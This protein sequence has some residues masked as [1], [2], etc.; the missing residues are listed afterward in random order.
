MKKTENTKCWQERG[1][2]VELVYCAGGS[3]YWYSHF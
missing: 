3:V 2:Q 1:A